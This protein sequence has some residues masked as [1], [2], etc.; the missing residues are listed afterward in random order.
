MSTLQEQQ[1]AFRIAWLDFAYEV[2]T[3]IGIVTLTRKLGMVE[4][5]WVREARKRKMA[6]T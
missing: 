2:V 6:R 5:D 4:R 1:E 3:S